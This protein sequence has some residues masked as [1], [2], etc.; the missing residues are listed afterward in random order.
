MEILVQDLGKKYQYE[1]IFS[2][3]SYTFCAGQSYAIIGPNGSGKSTLLQ[4]L[5]G[6]LPATKGQ[7]TYWHRE[8]EID[9]GHFFRYIG[10]AAPYQELIE[11]FTLSELLHFHF[12]FKPIREGFNIKK[13]VDALYMD[14]DQDKRIMYF[15]SGMKQ[16]L[17][18][19][20]C[21][22]T[23][24]PV[25]FLDEPT[26]NLDDKGKIWYHE[27]IRDILSQRLIIISSNNQEEYTFCN[28]TIGL[29]D[30]K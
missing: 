5:S 14:H 4:I 29:P 30:F 6:L 3:F 1:W 22:F 21:F 7:L 16:R 28:Q 9:P 2:K 23:E 10:I 12:K 19:G 17:K 11:E 15:S 26:A 25:M 27:N 18:L 13:I 20:L 8:K 24:S